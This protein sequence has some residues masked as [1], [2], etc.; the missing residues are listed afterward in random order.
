[1]PEIFKAL[2][3]DLAKWLLAAMLTLPGFISLK[4]Y[5]LIS[6]VGPRDLKDQVFEA[7]LFGLLHLILLGPL[8]LLVDVTAF[9][10]PLQW[11]AILIFAVVLPAIWPIIFRVALKRLA[12]RQLVLMTSKNGWDDL[13]QRKERC[14]VLFHLKDG[15]KL[16][17]YYGER[18]F[19]AVYPNSGH[20]YVEE[21]WTLDTEGKFVDKVPDTKG[22]VIR[23]EDYS[24]IEVFSAEGELK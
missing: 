16:G 5:S 17:G 1:M 19:A 23:P 20:M 7:L 18:S 8:F 2:E 13:F 3:L 11:A 6:P 14:F 10:R 12:R 22:F 21:T 9:S 4:I 15:S 24:L